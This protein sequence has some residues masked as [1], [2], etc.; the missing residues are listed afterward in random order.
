MEVNIDGINQ[1]VDAYDSKI[2]NI[3]LEDGRISFSDLAIQIGLS[4]ASVTSRIHRLQEI[5]LIEK[6]TINT[7]FTYLRKNIAVYLDIQVEP[8]ALENIAKVISSFPEIVVVYQMT[9]GSM[10]HVHGFFNDMKEI[11]DFLNTHINQLDGVKDVRVEFILK[12]FKS[13]FV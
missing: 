3:L 11:S 2:I 8:I 10:L 1:V 9:G 4:R 12:K 6:F 7:H 13:D 5:G